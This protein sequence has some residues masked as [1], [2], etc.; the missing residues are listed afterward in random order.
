MLS[1]TV[2]WPY[3]SHGK[4]ASANYNF[5]QALLLA[6]YHTI[7]ISLYEVDMSG[8][9]MCLPRV[10]T[11]VADRTGRLEFIYASLLATRKVFDVYS[12]VPVER[13]SGICFTLWAQFNHAFL[14]CVKL[15]TSEAHGWDSQHAQNVLTFPDIL[16]NQVKALKEVISRRGLVVETALD[17]KDM[18]PRL[19]RKVQRA[20]AW[21]ES[22]RLSRV[23]SQ[24]TSDQ[25]SDPN[26]ALEATDAG[27]PLPLFDDSFWQ[28]LFD[29]NW[30]L[31][32]GGLST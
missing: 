12:L 10:A 17:G 13:L 29:D 24:G 31:V 19:L 25:S 8:C 5:T 21:Y 28:D 1:K 23:D 30:M 6:T 4:G 9:P 15:L 26:G 14:N 20:L 16:H 11:K 32:G 2:S 3:K 18:F 27:E 22:S 7:E